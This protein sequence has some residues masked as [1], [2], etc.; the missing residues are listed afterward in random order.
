MDVGHCRFGMG[1][2]F[3]FLDHG[4][5][6]HFCESKIYYEGWGGSDL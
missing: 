1:E 6:A 5:E 2:F 4:I 3:G